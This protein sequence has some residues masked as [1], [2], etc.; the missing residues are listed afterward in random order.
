MH[1]GVIVEEGT[2]Y[3]IYNKSRH[4]FSAEFVGLTNFLPARDVG[5]RNDGMCQVDTTSGQILCVGA[6]TSSQG[7]GLRIMVRR[8]DVTRAVSR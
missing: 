4:G 5:S 3:D 7:E 1:D 6:R 8:E 2:P